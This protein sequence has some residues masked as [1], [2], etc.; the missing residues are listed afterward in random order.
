MSLDH[1]GAIGD[2]LVDL[3]DPGFE[4]ITHVR[5]IHEVG[6]ASTTMSEP[7]KHCRDLLTEASD[8]Q[9]I[10]ELSIVM[11]KAVCD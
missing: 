8:S 5:H 4:V 3:L 2:L 10:Q 1:V 11:E 7:R 9:K 6:W